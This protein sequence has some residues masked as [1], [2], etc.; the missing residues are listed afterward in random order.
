M[1]A[2]RF[3]IAAS[4]LLAASPLAAQ[5]QQDFTLVNRTGY[6]INEVYVAPSASDDWEEDVMGRDILEA[7]QSVDIGFSPKEKTC[8]YDVKVV[9]TD[10]EE[11]QW[12]RFDLCT[13][14]RIRIFYNR[15]NGETWAEYE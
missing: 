6:D 5:G 7:G 3:A 15:R 1:T 8:I 2:S 11:A 10:G 9:Y 12:D 13:V 4:L 14:S